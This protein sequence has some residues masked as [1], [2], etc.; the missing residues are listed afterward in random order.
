MTIVES[1]CLEYTVEDKVG[2][3]GGEDCSLWFCAGVSL[4]F[5]AT[6]SSQAVVCLRRG[7]AGGRSKKRGEY[8]ERDLLGRITVFYFVLFALQPLLYV[9]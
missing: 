4:A 3:V 6:V 1:R 9:E 2:S 5:R 8:E 7:C